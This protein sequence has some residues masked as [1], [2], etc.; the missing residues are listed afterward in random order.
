MSDLAAGFPTLERAPGV[1]P[2]DPEALDAWA[3]GPVPGAG[4]L[5]AARF[6]L[7]LWNNRVAWSAGPFDAV[8]ALAAWD[9]AHRAAFLR[10][11][12]S[13]WWP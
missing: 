4:A 7:T 2:F 8:E 1:R 13:P 3:A 6:M 10:W 5:H 12:R 9:Q 11:A